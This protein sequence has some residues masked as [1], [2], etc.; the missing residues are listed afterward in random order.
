MINTQKDVMY[1][2][3]SYN[4]IDNSFKIPFKIRYKPDFAKFLSNWKIGMTDPVSCKNFLRVLFLAVL[5]FF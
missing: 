3:L 5:G 2:I 1:F 4:F